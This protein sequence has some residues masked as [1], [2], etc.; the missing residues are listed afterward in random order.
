MVSLKK[1]LKVG[2]NY[3][4]YIMKL[5]FSELLVNFIELIILVAI[6]LL[7]MFPVSAVKVIL[8]SFVSLFTKTNQTVY[9]IYNIVFLII[10]SVISLA[11]FIY[12]FNK[13]YE[14][15]ESIRNRKR[16]TKIEVKDV[17]NGVR[18][19][20]LEDESMELPKPAQKKRF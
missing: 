18:K 1:F 20:E 14:D 15:I 16:E 3:I 19:I 4:D 17:K 10:N 2:K 9:L 7:V 13:R 5:G 12:M 6:S 8:Y 11:L